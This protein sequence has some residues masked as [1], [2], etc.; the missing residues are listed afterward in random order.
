MANWL[1]IGTASLSLSPSLHFPTILILLFSFSSSTIRL[2]HFLP[3]P[4]RIVSTGKKR[5]CVLLHCGDQAGLEGRGHSLAG[6]R[7]PEVPTTAMNPYQRLTLAPFSLM[8]PPRLP[9]NRSIEMSS[10]CTFLAA[11]CNTTVLCRRESAKP[12]QSALSISANLLWSSINLNLGRFL[13]YL[14][15]LSTLV[16]FVAR[17]SNTKEK[18]C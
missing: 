18:E 14:L 7:P 15:F 4:N 13:F 17:Q 3:I 11:N 6:F 5:T 2:R 16:F 1:P 9:M 10:C 8:T 12:V